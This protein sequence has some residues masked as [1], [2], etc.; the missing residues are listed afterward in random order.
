MPLYNLPCRQVRSTLLQRGWR[1][2]PLVAKQAALKERTTTPNQQQGTRKASVDIDVWDLE[3]VRVQKLQR[4]SG[5]HTIVSFKRRRHVNGGY[6]TPRQVFGR[7][8]CNQLKTCTLGLFGL[9][10]RLI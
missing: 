2:R 10:L 1:Q 5:S 3:R 4:I 6:S 9:G 8:L 7:T